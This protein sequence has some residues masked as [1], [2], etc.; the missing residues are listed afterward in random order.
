MMSI[1]NK[2]IKNIIFDFGG[3]IIN[4]DYKATYGAFESLGVKDL[5]SIISKSHQTGIFDDFEKGLISPNQFRKGMMEISKVPVSDTEFDWAWNQILLDIPQERLEKIVALKKDYNVFL[6]SNTNK[7][8]YDYYLNDLQEINGF[9]SFDTIFQKAYFSHEINMRKPDAE[10]YEFV[11]NDSNLV[12]E[13]SLFIDDTEINTKA[14]STL[15]IQIHH[16]KD[17]EEIVDIL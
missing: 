16:L 4:L 17:D 14:A 1:L 11:L 3:V 8:H 10:I 12:P 13:E 5:E 6:L 7:I 2:S 15:G 9:E